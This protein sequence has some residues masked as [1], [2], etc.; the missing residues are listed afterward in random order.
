MLAWWALA[1]LFSAD[2]CP[3]VP[4]A[5]ARDAVRGL[6]PHRPGQG[7]AQTARSYGRHALRAAITPLVT[8][9]GLDVGGALGGTVITET[10]F[11]LQGLGRTAVDA[12]RAGDLPTIMAHGP[13]RRRSSSWSPTSSS[14][15][16]T[17]SSTRACGCGNAADEPTGGRTTVLPRES[18]VRS[19]QRPGRDMRHEAYRRGRCARPRRGAR[20][21]Q[22]EHRRRQRRRHQPRDNGRRSR[23]TRRTR[24]GPAPEVPGAAKGGTFTVIRQT[25]DL[26]P[27]PAAGLLLRGPDERA[28]LR[29]R[30]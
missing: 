25:Q 10:T 15:C 27:G 13:G 26:P 8:I 17:P 14:T 19:H 6:R 30:P 1:F 4:G 22:R 29:P 23:P 3:A 2:L 9:A 16:C 12:V 5:D 28:A 20:R 7:P 11:G 18:T 21:V 24:M